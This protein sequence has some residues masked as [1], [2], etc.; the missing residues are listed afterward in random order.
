MSQVTR[1]Q[2]SGPLPGPKARQIIETDEKYTSPSYTRVY[3]LV[4]RRGCGSMVEDVDGN[5]FLDFHAGIAVASTGH[6]HPKVVE[7]IR[8]QAGDFLH[9]CSADFYFPAIADLSERLVETFPGRRPARVYYG[10][11]GTEAVEAAMKLA[12]YHTGRQRFIAFLGAFH[13]RTMGSLSLTSSKH[14]QRNK[15]GPLIPGVHHVEYPNPYRGTGDVVAQCRAS[16]ERL[17]STIC[18]ADEVAAIF[19][20]P[21]QGEGGYLVPPDDFPPMLRE[22]CDQN[23]ILLV[24]DEVQSGMGRTGKMWAIEHSGVIPDMICASKGIASGMPIGALIAKAKVM[25]WKP[26]AQGSTFGGNP[27]CISAALATLNLVQNGLMANAAAMG[28]RILER[29]SSWP[30]RFPIVGE[31]R[32]RGLMIGIELVKDRQ[33]KEPAAEE[34]KALIQR[35]F[36]RGL[37]LLDCG[38][39]TLRLMPA[40]TVSADEVDVALGII[41]ELLAG[42]L[43]N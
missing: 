38:K 15:F 34:C 14:T 41:E 30:E 26:G 33:T 16:I 42:F 24:A 10:N 19:V 4:M 3:P 8:R 22:L 18:P 12:R 2:I 40:L 7:A 23:G 20:E 36:E 21:I 5:Q 11:S 28:R 31:V 32:G 1:I 27:V 6:S 29:I 17:F 25:S 39:S 35:A 37:L 43:D 13:G 9:M